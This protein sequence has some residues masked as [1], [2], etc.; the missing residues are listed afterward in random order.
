M[1]NPIIALVFLLSVASLLFFHPRFLTRPLSAGR[2]FLVAL[3]QW[4]PLLLLAWLLANPY[5]ERVLSEQVDPVGLVLV[6]DSPSMGNEDGQSGDPRFETATRWTHEIQ[7]GP[8]G[9][10]LP[11]KMLVT[12]LSDWIPEGLSGSDFAE[13][14]RTLRS[15]HRPDQLAGVLFL[16]DGQDRS[17]SLSLPA[18]QDLGV[19]IHPIG[20]GPETGA[21]RIDARWVELPDT[22]FPGT[23]FLVRAVLESNLQS[24]REVRA[25][26]LFASRE[27][28]VQDLGLPEGTAQTPTLATV[29]SEDS[30]EF[31]LRLEV[32]DSD[33]GENLS[34]AEATV[35]IE[36]RP[37]TVLIL[38]TQ[39]TRASRDLTQAALAS[40]R[41]RVLRV[42]AHPEG[43]GVVW[44]LFRPIPEASETLAD[45]WRREKPRRI[46]AE[47]W[48]TTLA[49]LLAETSLVV[50]GREPW[51]GFPGRWGDD[52]ARFLAESRAG[53]LLLPGSEIG[54]EVL[55]ESSL[56]KL[57]DW[58][59]RRQ[60]SPTPLTLLF[61]EESRDHPVL[62]PV[63]SYL[64]ETW[65][66]GPGQTFDALPPL[67][68]ALILDTRERPLLAEAPLGLNNALLLAPSNLWNLRA[69]SDREYGTSFE[70]GLWLG[71]LD[72]LS[73]EDLSKR[74]RVRLSN[75]LPTVGEQV[76]IRVI[77]PGLRP[78]S[79]AA[80]LRISNP[81]GETAPMVVTP[82]PE[83]R[84]LGS[85]TWHPRNPGQY[86]I[87]YA[88]GT[89]P[90][91]VW[92]TERPPESGDEALDRDYL[93]R[94]A[95]ETGG[96]YFSF[97]DRERA[98]E[99]LDWTPRTRTETV[100][101]SL[102]HE[103][104]LGVIAAILFCAGWA[105]RRMW[106]LP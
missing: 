73:G 17:A 89:E 97:G 8:L 91:E 63:W 10:N 104:L 11:G 54:R 80:G 88:T 39:V 2:R 16:T 67:S 21:D 20:L 100:R 85:A 99:N 42:L 47:Q 77:D 52:C 12:R 94:L 87:R 68:R 92:V 26:I 24:P 61:P 1:N 83:W 105:L 66:I 13:A 98:L 75:P 65:E 3:L 95:K 57:L 103:G 50:L 45:F 81:Q 69:F 56:Q 86:E 59:D 35:T 58:M 55:P 7:E 37:P 15:S 90:I 30:G 5:A 93:G 102:R 106:S 9:E 34:I 79:L 14:F 60:D 101:A 74:I 51:T 40:G 6:D 62:A 53:V 43:S 70:E 41:Y 64:D 19:E 84:G 29:S 28:S 46:P 48:D 4:A 18:A 44:E 96:E 71:M 49:D 82:D 76:R 27:F 32:T 72:H 36:Q 31:P 78:G 22:A 25:R 38:E 23:P 33:T